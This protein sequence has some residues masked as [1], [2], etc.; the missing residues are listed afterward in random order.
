[1]HPLGQATL[2]RIVQPVDA[3]RLD[4]RERVA[5]DE[6]AGVAQEIPRSLEHGG[7]HL[8]DQAVA[9]IAGEDR[10]PLYG[11]PLRRDQEVARPDVARRH[12]RAGNR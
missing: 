12:G 8:A 10:G 5:Y 2:G 4:R 9:E 3:A 11:D 6:D 1:M 7:R